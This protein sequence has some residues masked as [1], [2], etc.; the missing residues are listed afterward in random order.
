MFITKPV[1][2]CSKVRSSRDSLVTGRGSKGSLW[3]YAGYCIRCRAWCL[4]CRVDWL[5]KY[6]KEVCLWNDLTLGDGL[7]EATNVAVRVDW[8]DVRMNV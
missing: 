2:V 1:R 8:G 6:S 7:T 5:V 3:G 4:R